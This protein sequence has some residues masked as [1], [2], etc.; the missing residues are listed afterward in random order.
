VGM[1]PTP[2]GRGY[3]FTAKDGGVF[4]YGDAGFYGS[5][6]SVPQARPIVAITS[7]SDGQGYWFTNNNGAVSAYGDAPYWGSAPQVIN[8]PIVGLAEAAGTGNFTGSSYASGS[9]GYDI[10]NFQTTNLPPSPHTIGVVEVNGFGLTAPNAY[11][12]QQAAW[13][14][15][16]LNLYTYLSCADT[17]MTTPCTYATGYAEGQY[18]YQAAT[19]AGVNTAV[20]WWL[21]VE[22]SNWSQ[23]SV[24][25]SAAASFG[26]NQ[27]VVQGAIDAIHGEGINSVGIY[28]SPGNWNSIVG[29]YQPAVPY[30]AASWQVNPATTCTSVRT[31]FPNAKLPTG[32]V[33]L[34]QYSS[35][36]AAYPLGGMS[37]AYDDDYAC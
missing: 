13:A 6:G 3:W 9:F 32:P 16:G 30:W 18:A 36:S 23:A 7:T 33:Q 37:T 21:D 11:L 15:A 19:A 2:D 12:A 8:K 14:G 29:N 28:A 26:A 34:V 4:A 31:Q 24:S 35:P 1:T 20:G 25:G 10:S 17:S 22:G 5:L 27:A